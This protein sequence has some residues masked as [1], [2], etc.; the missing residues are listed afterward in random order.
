M[1]GIVAAGVLTATLAV[2]VAVM[3]N[4]KQI[5]DTLVDG[6][7]YINFKDNGDKI[8]YQHAVRCNWLTLAGL[9]SGCLFSHVSFLGLPCTR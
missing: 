1:V 7:G 4:C 9:R 3:T 8:G 6:V 5:S 2:V